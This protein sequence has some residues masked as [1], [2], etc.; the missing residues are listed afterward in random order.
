M[1]IIIII[2]CFIFVAKDIA[3][4]ISNFPNMRILRMEGNTMGV[5]A[6]KTISKALEKHPEFEVGGFACLRFATELE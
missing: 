1:I 4:A 2:K 6:A 5:E 3:E